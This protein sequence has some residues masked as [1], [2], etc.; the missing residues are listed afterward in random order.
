MHKKAW[1]WIAIVGGAAVIG[2]V[3]AAVVVTTTPKGFE[4]ELGTIGSS[5]PQPGGLTLR[6]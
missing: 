1:F 5:S 2:G 3:V 4:P 6:F